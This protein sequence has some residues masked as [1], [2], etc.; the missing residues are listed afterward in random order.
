MPDLGF[1]DL[2]ETAVLVRSPGKD[3]FGDPLVGVDVTVTITGVLFEPG[4]TRENE[5][6][7][8]QV[9]ADGTL[10]VDPEL[11]IDFDPADQLI[12]RGERYQV[13][14]RPRYW[15][16]RLVEVPVRIVTG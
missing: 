12:I 14:G 10:Y 16:N 1:F 4:A 11:G 5:V 3:E 2:Q 9:E 15:L 8:N 13:V 7:A 6:N